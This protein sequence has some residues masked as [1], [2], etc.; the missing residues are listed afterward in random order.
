MYFFII[1]SV[2]NNYNIIICD[3]LLM[4]IIIKI[5]IFFFYDILLEKINIIR[6]YQIRF[7][8][9]LVIQN[10]ICDLIPYNLLFQLI[11]GTFLNISHL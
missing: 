7:L 1:E 11:F 2:Y 10:K 6:I 3:C 9:F 5:I 8:T 4:E